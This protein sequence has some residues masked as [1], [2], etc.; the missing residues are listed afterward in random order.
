M[1]SDDSGLDPWGNS[2]FVHHYYLGKGK[3]VNLTDVG[4]GAVFEHSSSVI[5][6]TT[7]FEGENISQG[8]AAAKALCPPGSKG[9]RHKAFD[10]D[11]STVTDVTNEPGLFSV[12]HSTF[13]RK[14]HCVL[15]ADCCNRSLIMQCSERYSIRDRFT[16][17]FSGTGNKGKSYDLPMS[18]PYDINYDFSRQKTYYGKF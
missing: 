14:A 11:H 4:L 12:G 9:H 6:A 1:F 18:K 10:S 8:V 2:D 5:N 3:P 16:D 15:V 17:P 7:A 13:Y